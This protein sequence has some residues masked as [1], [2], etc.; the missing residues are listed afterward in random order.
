MVAPVQRVDGDIHFSGNFRARRM[1]FGDDEFTGSHFASFNSGLQ[2]PVWRK[3]IQ[4]HRLTYGQEM[5]T[6]VAAAKR[7][8]YECRYYGG[9]TI[10]GVACGLAGVVPGGDR[11]AVIEVYK[12]GTTVLT[13][14]VTLDSSN[15]IRE[16]EAGT[17]V[18]TPTVA[19]GDVLEVGVT[20]GGSSGTHP[21]GLWVTVSVKENGSGG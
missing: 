16:S 19:E 20:L 21:R 10:L 13:G 5:A 14:A 7:M 4:E 1:E 9:G 15:T 6:D 8:I 2:S 11:T 12:N 18:T 3:F 17:L